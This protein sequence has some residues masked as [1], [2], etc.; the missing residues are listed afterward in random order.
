VAW[1]EQRGPGQVEEV[2]HGGGDPVLHGCAG[3]VI[4]AEENI[5]ALAGKRRLSRVG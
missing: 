1:G 3:E 5:D 4:A 2:A